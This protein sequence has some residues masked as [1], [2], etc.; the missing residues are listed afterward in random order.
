MFYPKC[1][2]CGSKA[3]SAEPDTVEYGNRHMG[4]LAS[5]R[6][7]GHAHPLLGAVSAAIS[8]GNFVYQRAPGG[9]LKRCKA[10]GNEFR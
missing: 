10:C 5:G 9:G 1:P 7:T 4:R 6:M 8:V 3:R 2:S